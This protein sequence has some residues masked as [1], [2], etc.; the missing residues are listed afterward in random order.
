[1]KIALIADIHHA[2]AGDGDFDVR[3]VVEAFVARAVETE[4]DALID[5]GDRID[6]CDAVTDFA[7]TAELA[8]I[9]ARFPGPRVHLK[10]NHDVVN[11]DSGGHERIFGRRP[12]NEVIDLGDLRVIGWQPSVRL[13]R[14]TGFPP[15]AGELDWLLAA[16]SSDDRPAI[17]ATHIPVSGASMTGNYYFE[18]NPDFATYP[19]HAEIRRAVEQTGRA[20]LWIS[21]HVHWNSFATVGNI[22]HLTIQSAS[23]TFT[24]NS[25][26]AGAFADLTITGAIA[27]LEVFGHDPLT[28]EMP[29]EVSAARRWPQPRP[30]V[31]RS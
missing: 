4:A 12:N 16:L 7:R 3:S 8:E 22:R 10:G 19:D 18:N 17:I 2:L 1:L 13:D 29:F 21:G 31:Q 5:L 23:E 25:E 28:I 27:R 6:D 9:F 30:Q 20:A 26:P 24:T 14:R 11:L 15:A